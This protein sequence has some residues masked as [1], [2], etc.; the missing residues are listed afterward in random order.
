[1]KI[2][3]GFRILIL[4]TLSFALLLTG[5]GSDGSHSED[6]RASDLLQQAYDSAFSGNP[7][8]ALT[9]A[10]QSLEIEVRGDTLLF[11]SQMQYVLDHITEAYET[12]SLYDELYPTN[13][14][15]DLIRATYLNDEDGNC[16]QIFAN[17]ETAFNQDYGGLDEESY[18]SLV[19]NGYTLSYFEDSCPTQYAAL[20]ALKAPEDESL[21][22]KCKQNYF[23]C[24]VPFPYIGPVLWVDNE[25]TKLMFDVANVMAV[26]VAL[27]P[28][29]PAG[30]VAFAAAA[31]VRQIEVRHKNKGCGVKFHWTW[32]NFLIPAGGGMALFWMS[33]QS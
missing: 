21:P 23:K 22:E 14:E 19:E 24:N 1:M 20:T 4:C 30:K 17:L 2:D 32:A 9:Y 8:E 27:L 33:S 26:V 10:N 31:A 5:C 12:L 18:W 29:D 25:K 7:S 3:I 15:D 16:D 6:T 11:K 13:G 28:T